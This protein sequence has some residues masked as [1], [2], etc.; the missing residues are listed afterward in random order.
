MQMFRLTALAGIA[1]AA[2][3]FAGAPASALST[4]E[5]SVK[6]QSAKEAGTLNGM[7]WNEFRKAQCADNAAT[8]NTA[9]TTNKKAAAPADEQAKG[10]TAKQCGAKYQAAKEAGTL[11]GMKWYDFRKAKCGPGA[12]A[13]IGTTSAKTKKNAAAQNTGTTAGGLSLKECGTKYQAAKQA[14]TLNGMKWNDFRKTEC[15]PGASTAIQA[16]KATKTSTASGGGLTMTE[17]S[18]KYQ[19]AKEAGTL[20]GLKWNDFRK[21]K[22]GADAADDETVPAQSEAEYTNDPAA[23]TTAAPKGVIFPRTVSSKYSNE[24]AGKARMHTCLQQYY[25]DKESNAL[26]GLKWI[27]KGGG[28]YSQCNARLK[29]T[30]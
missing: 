17:C 27:Q 12:A 22:C 10:L 20:G 7:N 9:A 28:Y 11:N 18:A 23:P 24:P 25:A 19:S 5:C 16:P 26:G 3:G 15:G 8:D 1:L 30:T 29:G 2:V 13:E 14:G 6:Y 21:S 4:K